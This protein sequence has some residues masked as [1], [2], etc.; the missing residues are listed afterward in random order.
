MEKELKKLQ[1]RIWAQTLLNWLVIQQIVDFKFGKC[2][3]STPPF[4]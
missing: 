2:C 1:V 4:V 3:L